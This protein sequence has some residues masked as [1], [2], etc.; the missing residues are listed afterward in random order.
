MT[1]DQRND[2]AERIAALEARE[3][4]L[5]QR[6]AEAEVTPE[7]RQGRAILEVIARDTDHAIDIPWRQRKEEDP[8]AA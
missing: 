7:Q 4:E 2:L 1:D 5:R 3:Q 6:E 8:D